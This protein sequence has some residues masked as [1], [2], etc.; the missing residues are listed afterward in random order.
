MKKIIIFIFLIIYAVVS[1][2]IVVNN[3]TLINE[4]ARLLASVKNGQKLFIGDL[5]DPE[6]NILYLANL[7]GT[8][9]EMG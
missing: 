7:K 4:T 6:R 3:K 5:N 1:I 2:D 9:F 8:P